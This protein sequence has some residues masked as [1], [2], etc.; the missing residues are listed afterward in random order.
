MTEHA[1]DP[2]AVLDALERALAHWHETE[3]FAQAVA[4]TVARHGYARADVESQLRHVLLRT[5]GRTMRL[6]LEE[7]V[8]SIGPFPTAPERVLV[9]ASGRVPGLAIEGVV[10]ALA[11]GAVAV[12]RPSRDET[13]L[14]H[15]LGSL[16]ATEPSLLERV[17][18]VGAGDELPWE[19]VDGAIVFGSD[20]TI[21]LVR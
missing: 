12:V 6:V 21:A 11:V 1:Q 15:L 2:A 10:A 17:E 14:H 19:R 8:G 3:G 13:V 7:E 9:L 18:V 5:R 20:E 4:E 16:A